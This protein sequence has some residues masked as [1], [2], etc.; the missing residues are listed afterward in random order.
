MF[1]PQLYAVV[2]FGIAPL[3]RDFFVLTYVSLYGIALSILLKLIDFR[4]SRVTVRYKWCSAETAISGISIVFVSFQRVSDV[5]LDALAL[6]CVHY[7]FVFAGVS[8][9]SSKRR[10]AP[11]IFIFIDRAS[12]YV[13]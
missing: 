4:I 5:E 1:L 2:A 10:R 6:V 12:S 3:L 13:W 8:V 11:S 9:L 7:L